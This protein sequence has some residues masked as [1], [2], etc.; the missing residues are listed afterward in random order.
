MNSIVNEKIGELK[1]ICAKFHVKRL[2]LFGSATSD[3]EF[4]P[5]TSDIDFLI[6]FEPCTPGEHC[7]RYF[8]MLEEL[9]SLFDR[10]VDL[11]EIKA[12][13]NPYFILEVNESRVLIYG[14]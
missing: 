10:H 2:E 6:E 1:G 14:S 5:E 4:N 7:D 13:K 8:G 3:M 12:M 9:E 11:V